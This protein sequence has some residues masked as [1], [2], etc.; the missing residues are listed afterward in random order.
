[1]PKFANVAPGGR[2]DS[3]DAH[4][5]D[6]IHSCAGILGIKESIGHIDFY[7]NNGEG[8]IEDKKFS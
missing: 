2:L 6:V 4:F 7:P 8:K 1:M 3:S 5:V